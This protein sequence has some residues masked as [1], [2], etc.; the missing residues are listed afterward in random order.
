MQQL[1]S[2]SNYFYP[3]RVLDKLGHFLKNPIKSSIVIDINNLFIIN[4]V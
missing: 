3:I 1:P 4:T 2:P